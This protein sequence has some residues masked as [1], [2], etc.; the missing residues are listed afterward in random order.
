MKNEIIIQVKVSEES[1][2]IK[3]IGTGTA[4]MMSRAVGILEVVK[5]ELLD[6]VRKTLM[7]EK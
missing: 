6:G 1:Q 7:E 4:G 2:E 5:A 3:V